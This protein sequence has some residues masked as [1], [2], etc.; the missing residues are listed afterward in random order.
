MM[1]SEPSAVYVMLVCA[2]G[3]AVGVHVRSTH[4]HSVGAS[5]SVLGLADGLVDGLALGLALGRVVA[6][7]GVGGGGQV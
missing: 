2:L 3:P 1:D 6:G 7:G 5:S 4:A